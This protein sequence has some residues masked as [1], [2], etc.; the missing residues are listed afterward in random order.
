MSLETIPRSDTE[1]LLHYLGRKGLTGAWAVPDF[2]GATVRFKAYDGHGILLLDRAGTFDDIATGL[3]RTPRAV[4]DFKGTGATA[5]TYEHEVTYADG[6][7]QSF[8]NGARNPAL[9][10]D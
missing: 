8:P 1:P 10:V 6:A 7:I 3:V 9:L 4:G 2:T 5:I